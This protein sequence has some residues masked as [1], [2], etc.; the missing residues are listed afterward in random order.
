MVVL[1]LLGKG[2]LFQTE[3]LDIECKCRIWRNNSWMT[4]G[5]ISI[6]RRTYES[7]SLA[8]AQLKKN[9]LEKGVVSGRNA[10]NT[11]LG[12]TFVP[13]TDYLALTNLE[14]EGLSTFSGRIKLGSICQG[15]F[16]GAK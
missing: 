9:E 15:A 4:P 5:A 6:V 3:Q 8:N 12:H 1:G 7:S 14:L 10:L 11:H 13:A 16:G 2:C